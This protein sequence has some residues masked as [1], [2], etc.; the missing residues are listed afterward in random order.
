M[1]ISYEEALAIVCEHRKSK[2]L[3]IN[4]DVRFYCTCGSHCFTQVNSETI[5]LDKIQYGTKHLYIC[6]NCKKVYWSFF[7]RLDTENTNGII[8]KV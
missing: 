5:P 3:D 2:G 7:Y 8:M 6:D 1:S 4:D